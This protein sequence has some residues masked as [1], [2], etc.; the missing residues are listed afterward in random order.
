MSDDIIHKEADSKGKFYMEDEIG[1]ISELRYSKKE[2]GEVL[3]IKHTETRT[4]YKGKGLAAILV[5]KSIDYVR[6]NNI[7]IIPDCPYA[8]AYF[9]R[10]KEYVDV[11]K[12]K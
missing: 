7:K 5:K 1:I 12:I 3:I 2:N 8:K 11:L 6:E 4:E 9:S 10:H